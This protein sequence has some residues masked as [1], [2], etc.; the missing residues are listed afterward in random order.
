MNQTSDQ[1]IVTSILNNG[2]ER[3]MPVRGIAKL[4]LPARFFEWK[5]DPT[6]QLGCRMFG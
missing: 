6:G 1:A 5:D 3:D 2:F 4:I